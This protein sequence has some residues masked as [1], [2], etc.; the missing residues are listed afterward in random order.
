[1]ADAAI[2]SLLQ[3]ATNTYTNAIG[4]FVR[5]AWSVINRCGKRFSGV[6]K[7]AAGSRHCVRDSHSTFRGIVE[8]FH[9]VGC[10]TFDSH[11]Y[12]YLLKDPCHMIRVRPIF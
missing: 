5:A 3:I 6:T 11:K 7:E 2:L 4:I 9:T 1:V 8:R 10:E 12:P